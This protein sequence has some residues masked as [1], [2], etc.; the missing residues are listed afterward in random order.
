MELGYAEESSATKLWHYKLMV[1]AIAIPLAMAP[2]DGI[3]HREPVELLIQKLQL[4]LVLGIDL[5]SED[6]N[7]DSNSSEKVFASRL[8]LIGHFFKK[9]EN[10]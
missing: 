8:P 5:E 9:K 4:K 10:F 6:S 7:N 1:P 3:A 2:I